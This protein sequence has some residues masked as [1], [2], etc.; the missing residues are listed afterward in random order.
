M[1]YY[2]KALRT[3]PDYPEALNN[4]GVALAGE[5]RFKEAIEKFTAA[6][7]LRPDYGK[8]HGNLAAAFYSTGRYEQAMR[9]IELARRSGFE[10][11]ARLVERV[12]E[13]SSN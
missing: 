11:P 9:E 1:E 2:E 10:P 4:L 12:S 7:R 3:R 13:K 5:R 8:A 6:I